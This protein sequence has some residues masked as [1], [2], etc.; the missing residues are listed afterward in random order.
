MNPRRFVFALV[1][2]LVFL[3]AT[4]AVRAQWLTQEISLTNGWNAV[5]LHVDPSHDTIHNLVGPGAVSTTKIDE[6]WMWTPA[7]GTLQFVESP[8]NPLTSGSQWIS[9]KRATS[10]AGSELKLSGN[11]ACLVYCSEDYTWRIKGRPAVPNHKWTVSGL[12]LV[13]FPTVSTGPPSF[14]DFLSKSPALQQSLEIFHY[15]GGELGA[16]NPKELFTFRTTPVERGKAFWMRT[17]TLFN[18]YYGP[19]ELVVSN[20][21]G[22]KF[23]DSLSTVS[24][25]VRNLTGSPLTVTLSHVDSETPPVTTPAQ[26]AIVGAPPLLV[27]GALNTTDLTHAY[28]A[29]NSGDARQWTLAA[30][31]LPGSEAEIVLGLNRSAIAAN[32]GELLAGILR[33]TDSL[34][35][36]Q[37]DAPVS[38][39]AA[40]NAG[41]WVGGAMVTQ[42]GQYL[43]SYQTGPD[44]KPV[45]STDP[46]DFG[47]YITTGINTNLA[48]VPRAFPLRL[49]VHNPEAADGAVLLQRVFAGFD[50][51]T[52]AVVTTR[53]STLNRGLLREARRISATHLPW[54]EANS[55]WA[56]NGRLGTNGAMTASVRSDFG[57]HASNPFLHTYHPDH[58]NRDALFAGTLPQGV[59]SYTVARDVT[60]EFTTPSDDFA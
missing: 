17:G 55:G 40:S 47:A 34:G 25:R 38:A 48:S 54:T 45:T 59:E 53:E 49:I 14:E 26:P 8:Q 57:D 33:F 21:D 37:V 2:C 15:P 20:P 43:K 12:N 29:L 4:P 52:N 11:L 5:Y 23:G 7:P 46:A 18:R 16:G 50:A 19:F 3:G 51:N 13:G 42:V 60:L 24:L 30:A 1:L 35:Y 22:V 32:P 56:F 9:W 44:N 39:T 36:S 31:G 41:L 27:R 28:S 58:D 10:S 6:V